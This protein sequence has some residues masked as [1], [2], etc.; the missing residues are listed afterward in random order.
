MIV[1]EIH[2]VEKQ[3]PC[4]QRETINFVFL[5]AR[6]SRIKMKMTT[7][8]ER[9]LHWYQETPDTPVLNWVD[10]RCQVTQTLTFRNLT[11][12]CRKVAAAIAHIGVRKGERAVLCFP[13]GL[14]FI[15]AFLG[16]MFAGIT[17]GKL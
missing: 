11:E 15:V 12:Q 13:A 6:D 16:C 9:L 7:I 17:A 5:K 14:D 2:E 4:M 3:F 10:S 1:N 8:V